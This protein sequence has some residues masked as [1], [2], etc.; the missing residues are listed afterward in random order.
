MRRGCKDIDLRNYKTVLPWVWDCIKRHYKRYD[1]RD[2]LRHFGVSRI[3]YERALINYDLS[4]FTSAVEKI[5]KEVVRRIANRDLELPPVRIRLKTDP[6]TGKIRLIGCEI[7]MQQVFDSVAV[8]AAQEIWD[9]RSVPFQVSS[10]KGRGPLHG[11]KFIQ[12]WVQADNRA[13]RYAKVH[14]LPYTLKC[15]HHTKGD[16]TKCFPSARYEIFMR[17]FRRDCG[18]EDL[19]WLWETLF[20]SHRVE[21][22]QGF[23]IGSNVS[24][25]AMQYMLSFVYRFAMDLATERR[26]KR[27]PMITHAIFFMDDLGLIGSNR[28]NIKMAMRKIIKYAKEA[29]GLII[30][31]NWHIKDLETEPLDMMGY[32][33]HRN[34]KLTIRGRVFV[35]GRRMVLRYHRLHK[36][37]IEQARRLT[38][39]KGHFKH[40]KIK[41]VKL[42]KNCEEKI[43]V[44]DACDY[45]ASVVSRYDREAL[46]AG[47]L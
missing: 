9:R 11:A 45:A 19:L 1:F 6:S 35:R 16:V 37:T 12:R 41:Y 47:M 2:M 29:F 5:A 31:T 27:I 15:K 7:A 32:V 36:L 20:K 40:T 3:D 42:S 10:I 14:G 43:D 39:Y 34:G 23:M 13:A 30:K 46:Y 17:Y 28:K 38:A 18:N 21:G 24:Q 4:I 44:M 22:Y 8:N 25:W 33:I 26:G